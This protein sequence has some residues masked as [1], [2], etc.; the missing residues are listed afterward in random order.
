MKRRHIVSIFA[1]LALAVGSSALLTGCAGKSYYFKAVEQPDGTVSYEMVGEITS[2]VEGQSSVASTASTDTTSSAVSETPV[3]EAPV[4]EA[5]QESSEAPT[6]SS[7]ETPTESSEETPTESSEETPTESSE[8]TSAST[9][10][11]T[12]D[13]NTL[14]VIKFEKPDDW[15]ADSLYLRVYDSNSN[16]NTPNGQQMTLGSDGLYYVVVSKLADNGNEFVNP[17]FMFLSVSEATGRYVQSDEGTIDG[18][19]TYGVERDGRKFLLVEK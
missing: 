16:Q 2:K 1:A 12:T 3:S 8:E 5:P 7:E 9:G 13:E 11:I 15:Q 10:D 19:K 17:R 6:E 18:S 4:S 14:A